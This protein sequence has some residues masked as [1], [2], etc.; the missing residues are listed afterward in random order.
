MFGILA[1]V[2]AVYRP[3]ATLTLDALMSQHE[4]RVEVQVPDAWLLLRI[5]KVR[6]CRGSWFRVNSTSR[7]R[8]C[9]RNIKQP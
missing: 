3:T 9:L 4:L 8:S 2:F 1:E 5:Q 6:P 7:P